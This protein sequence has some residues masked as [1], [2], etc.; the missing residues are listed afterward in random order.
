ML[1]L[2][3]RTGTYL[4]GLAIGLSIA[5]LGTAADP[6]V[7]HPDGL[8]RIY[9]PG[10]ILQD[11]NGDDRIDYVSARII[12]PDSPVPEEVAAAAAIAARLG[13]ETSGLSL[14]LVIH[15]T[16]AASADL[17]DD[18]PRIVLGGENPLLPE[19]VIRRIA[20]LESEQGLVTL[21]EGLLVVAGKDPIGTRTAAEAFAARSPYLWE[22]I[23]RENG[24]TFVRLTSDLT[25]LLGEGG[26]EVTEVSFD[27]MVFEK[28]RNEVVSATSS[29]RLAEGAL[30]RARELFTELE[31]THSR[32]EST[33]KLSYSSLATWH[34]SL[35]D[36]VSR[37]E[38]AVS[39]VGAPQRILTPPRQRVQM[40]DPMGEPPKPRPRD[41]DLSDLF[42]T[43]GLLVDSDSDRIPDTTE[44]ILVLPSEEESRSDM[45]SRGSAHLAARI[46]LESTGVAFP[47]V[48]LDSEIKDPKEERSPVLLGG[49][50]RLSD[51]LRRLGK[52]RA[53][54]PEPG[55]GVIEVVPKAFKE[56]P[57][58]VVSG[59]DIDGAEAAADYLAGRTPYLWTVGRGEATLDDVESSVRKLLNGQTTAGQAALALAR[60]EEIVSTLEDRLEEQETELDFVEVKAFFEEPSPE[61]DRYAA[62]QIRSRL[63]AERVE[64]T[65]QG[66]REPKEVFEEKPE[67]EWEVEA[68]WKLFR[69]KALPSI[70]K[71]SNVSVEL[72]VSE[73]PELRRDLEA[74]IRQAI[75]K[76]GASPAEVTVL[77]AY[78]QGLSWLEDRVAPAIKG[79]PVSK[80]EVTCKTLPMNAPKKWRFHND[81]TRWL[82]ELY[83][84]DEVLSKT[85][86]LP[87]SAFSFAM[88]DQGEPIYVATATD[89]SGEVL[90]RDSFSPVFYERPFLDAFPDK[91][92]VTVTTGW[93][94]VEINGKTLVDERLPTDLDRVW[95]FYQGTALDKVYE[96]VKKSTGGK[97]ELKKQPF[98]HTLRFELEAS[99]PD[100]RLGIDEEHVSSLES[101][102]DDV[103]F[104][105]L[106]FFDEVVEEAEGKPVRSRSGAPGNIL[107][108][109]HPER[110]GKPPRLVITYSE[111]ASSEP[112]VVIEYQ[113]KGSEKKTE[114]RKL[115]TVKLPRPSAYRAE[116]RAGGDSL[117]RLYLL[118]R[119]EKP[120]PVERLADLLDNLTRLQEAG[121]FT[122][123]L[124]FHGVSE[125]AIELEAPNA[126]GTRVY[127]SHPAPDNIPPPEPYVAGQPLV[128]W[129]HVVSPEESEQIAHRLGT[130]PEVTTYVA[131]ESYQGRP[132]SVMEITLPMEAK[133]IS[134]A[135]M[136]TWK[137]V[138]SLQGRQHANEVSSTS[139]ILRL[140][141]LLA[142]DPTYKR[143]LEKMNV[144][145][146]PV[147]NPDGA[148]LAYE[149][150]KLNPTHCQHAG[151]YS[152]LGPDVTSQAR[153]PDTLL[154]EALVIRNVFDTWLPDIQLNPHGYPSHEWVHHFANYYPYGFRSYWIPRGWYTVV[155]PPED[156]RYPHHR[157]AALAM[158]DFIAEEVSRDPDVRETNLRIYDRYKR[159][160]IRWQP[161]L[162]NLEIHKDTAIYSSRRGGSAPRVGP[163]GNITVFSSF[164]EA[165]DETAQGE[166][167]DLVTR[168]GFGF[169]MASVRFL[170]EAEYTLYRLEEEQQQKIKLSLTRPR[171]IKPARLTPGATTGRR[172]P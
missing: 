121:I 84:A 71:G 79:R 92:R 18:L 10:L 102:H 2:K 144:V 117:A 76:A 104:D 163:T 96:H 127:A 61:F 34:L 44:T 143:Y 41:F 23:G 35:T 47:L 33:N 8:A 43:A 145:V 98:F 105:T 109:I 130:L 57:A 66:R 38:V 156:P 157:D 26:V 161:H 89:E 148:A 118:L 166:W 28:D 73:A 115:E 17:P 158:Q 108:W 65:S 45:P 53:A 48:K 90:Y 151:R 141:E 85:L 59:G 16:K 80:L 6:D 114:T 100:Y 120:E 51:K 110:R 146:Q 22:I 101:I 11:R 119:L 116:T 64:V 62:E 77:S 97:P 46:G 5:A 42:T 170:D 128:S 153:D 39:R 124:G 150:Q 40:T 75:E 52:R 58:V 25:E 78:K 49:A 142:T 167:M 87:L 159:W 160:A 30:P 99:E 164:T 74:Q 54:E 135:K 113:E 15:A 123:A 112:K 72:R 50:N 138:F 70:K 125:I 82:G 122:D 36:G 103:Y 13:F 140:S 171:P 106:A 24:E 136:S 14:P 27:E 60:V 37:D 12:L 7:V 133:L 3:A 155:V 111:N 81:P 94:E 168:M 9:E 68:F 4:V 93:L 152:A 154:T 165:M 88:R 67:L 132:V 129:D 21:S 137:P 134:Q 83:P 86:D 1:T 63:K 31:E 147:M 131:G 107:P 29:V 172:D 20:S 162:Y 55:T 95:D 149:L 19:E 32:G 91:A 126:T 56:T 169:L 139:H 69:E